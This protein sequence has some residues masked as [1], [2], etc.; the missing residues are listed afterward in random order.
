[1]NSSAEGGACNVKSGRSTL[2]VTFTCTYPFT[3]RNAIFG[4]TL[5]SLAAVQVVWGRRR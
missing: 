2:T 3:L 5:S 4:V 1:M